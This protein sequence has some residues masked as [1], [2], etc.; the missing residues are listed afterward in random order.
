MVKLHPP[1]PPLVAEAMFA[2]QLGPLARLYL[3]RT[4]KKERG[5]LVSLAM[6]G[7]SAPRRGE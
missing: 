2:R 1:L 4:K 3:A 6:D 5:P 7:S